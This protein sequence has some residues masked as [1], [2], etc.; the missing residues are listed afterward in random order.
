[1]KRQ[2]EAGVHAG[3]PYCAV[4]MQSALESP[5]GLPSS[6]T[7]A[8]WMLGLV[9]PPDVRR[10]FTLPPESRTCPMAL[11]HDD[12]V[13]RGRPPTAVTGRSAPNNNA[14]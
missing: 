6:S 10:S 3:C 13:P 8:A 7:N 11:T 2:A 9:T 4:G 5:I 14:T 12:S 1:M